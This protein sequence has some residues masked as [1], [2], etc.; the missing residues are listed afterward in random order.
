MND[1]LYMSAE[2]AAAALGVS[3]TTVYAYVS[4]KII[5]SHKPP[6]TRV[7]RYWRAD[8]E[9]VRQK[10]PVGAALRDANP[11]VS[12]TQITV[13]TEAG[14]FYRGYSA[15]ALAETE[16][17]ESVAALLWQADAATVF[18]SHPPDALPALKAFWPVL[19]GLTSVD[20]A[21]A[22][23]PLIEKENPRAY[24][25]TPAGFAR[26]A[27]EVMR[28]FAAIM[29]GAERASAEP[30]HKVVTSRSPKAKALEDVVRRLLVLS[31]DHEL[32]PTTYAVRAVANTGLNPYRLVLV[33]LT[34]S[35]GRRLAYGRAEALSRLLEEITGAVDPKE[36]LVGR[37]RDGEPL[38][39]FGSRLYA[40]GDPRAAALLAALNKSLDGD[41]ELK[42]LNAAIS[43]V[44]DV[45]GQE[46]D[47]ALLNLFIGRQ[48]GLIRQDGLTLRLGRIAGWIAHAMEQYHGRD[49]VRPHA[50]YVG[51]LPSRAEH[52]SIASAPSGPPRRA[53]GT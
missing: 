20:K 38:P 8:I 51:P 40:H 6:G 43:V 36:V 21:L 41:P 17:L 34:A 42:R 18:P 26:T 45:T 19:K 24:D 35:T 12:E 15:I 33:G 48:L 47:F 44:R 30:L 4:R 14:P 23:F 27:G 11:L 22:T 3:V 37:L 2:E 39:G 1:S 28:W 9:R 32:D 16:T 49:L 10:L 53:R 29:V 7:S 50:I 46:P 13:I 52:P 5:R 25:L 31:A